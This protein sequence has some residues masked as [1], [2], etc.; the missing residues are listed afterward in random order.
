MCISNYNQLFSKGVKIVILDEADSMTYDAQFA[1]R[2]VIENYTHN[3]RFCLICNYISKI[4]P[5][6][7]SRCITLRFTNI[8]N[9]EAV[10]RLKEI[11]GKENVK[12]NNSGLQTIT[13]I[14]FL[15]FNHFFLN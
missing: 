14:C 13:K 15:F 1:L 7:Q 9:K 12:Y 5:A 8:D 6:L 4:I 10:K 11:C 3:T 2:R